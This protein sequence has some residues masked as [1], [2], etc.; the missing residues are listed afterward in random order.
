VPAQHDE[1]ARLGARRIPAKQNIGG[2]QYYGNDNPAEARGT[3]FRLLREP[4]DRVVGRRAMRILLHI[5]LLE[6]VAQMSSR[7]FDLEGDARAQDL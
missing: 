7:R 3:T 1:G 5:A 6:N 2:K 4:L